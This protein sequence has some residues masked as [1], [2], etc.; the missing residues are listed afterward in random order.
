MQQMDRSIQEVSEHGREAWALTQ[1]VSEGAE[2][3]SLTVAATIRDMRGIRDRTS[4]AKE[5]LEKL[6]DV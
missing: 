3:G 5:G 2:Q 6:V 4:E 1:Q